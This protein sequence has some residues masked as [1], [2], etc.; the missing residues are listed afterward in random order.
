MGSSSSAKPRGQPRKLLRGGDKG[1]QGAGG[2]ADGGGSGTTPNPRRATNAL[3][4]ERVDR[5][6]ARAVAQGDQLALVDDGRDIATRWRGQ[7][8]GFVR[9]ADLIRVRNA[10]GRAARITKIVLPV[11]IWVLLA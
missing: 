2:S 6:V 10:G 11:E 9:R 1:D 3:R 4:L 7:T 8:L 5:S